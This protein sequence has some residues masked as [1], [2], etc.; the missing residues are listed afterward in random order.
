MF[1]FTRISIFFHLI[2]IN[3]TNIGIRYFHNTFAFYKFYGCVFRRSCYR[4]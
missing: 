2:Y 1:W 4:I 3:I